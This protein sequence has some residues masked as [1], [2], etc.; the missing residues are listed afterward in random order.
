[1][2]GEVGVDVFDFPGEVV[3]VL[4]AGVGAEAVEGGCR[5]TASPRQWIVEVSSE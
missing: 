1:M 3:C 4:D 5:W 2:R